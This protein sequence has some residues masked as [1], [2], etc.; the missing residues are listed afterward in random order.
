MSDYSEIQIQMQMNMQLPQSSLSHSKT[1]ARLVKG[2]ILLS[3]GSKGYFDF[4]D[5]L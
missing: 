5:Y 2:P 4:S 3:A 1:S